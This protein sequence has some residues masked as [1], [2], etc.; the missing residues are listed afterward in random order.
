MTASVERMAVAAMRQ[1]ALRYA[2]HGWPVLP[3]SFRAWPDETIANR[4]LVAPKYVDGPPIASLDRVQIARWWSCT[5]Y[6]VLVPTGE[7]FDAFDVSL[8]TATR[9]ARLLEQKQIRTPMLALPDDTVRLLVSPDTSARHTLAHSGAIRLLTMGDWTPVPP[10]VVSGAQL[11][12]II[13]PEETDWIVA[14]SWTARL[15][16]QLSAPG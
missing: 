8:P 1:A 10:L 11:R 9:A 12:W 6:P 15:A 3:G 5:P 7:L 2:R 4:L 14:D 16:L 13:S